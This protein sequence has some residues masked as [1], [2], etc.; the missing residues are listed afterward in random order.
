[1][2]Q[3]LINKEEVREKMHDTILKKMIWIK[4]LNDSD[5]Q[6][7][8]QWIEAYNVDIDVL[9][10]YTDKRVLFQIVKYL[11]NKELIFD[12]TIRWL[13]SAKIENLLYNMYF[14]KVFEELKT[15]YV[16]LLD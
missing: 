16:G 5:R 3:Q 9:K 10:F 2:E 12:A 4:P 11:G 15:F 8:K 6:V 13:Y 7:R 14:Y 1:M